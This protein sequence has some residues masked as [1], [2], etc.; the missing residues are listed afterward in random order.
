MK[1]FISLILACIMLLPLFGC[2]GNQGGT[3]STDGSAAGTEQSAAT[4]GTDGSQSETVPGETVS[5]DTLHAHTYTQTV[6]APTCTDDGYTTYTCACGETYV[7]DKVAAAG[8]SFGQWETTVEPT[9]TSTGTSERKCAVC[10]EKETR[11]LGKKLANHTHSYVTEVLDVATCT[12]EGVKR[13]TCT[14]GESYTE[15]TAKA[16]HSYKNT[17]VK[18]DCVNGGYTTHKCSV[19]DDAYVDAQTNALGHDYKDTVVASTCVSYGH[20]KYSCSRCGSY[21]TQKLPLAEHAYQDATCTTAK[22]CKVCGKTSGSALGHSYNA[23]G[24]CSRCGVKNPQAETGPVTFSATIKSDKNEKIAGITVTVYVDS[25]AQPAGSAVTGSNGVA[26][27]S[28]NRGG[29]YKVV[30]S[31]IPAGYS[32]KESYTFSSH[33]VN[34]NLACVPV[35]DPLDHSRAMY[36]VGSTMADFTLTDTDGNTYKLSQLMQQKKLIILDFWYVTCAPCKAEFPYF[37][38]ALEQYGD[39]ITLLALNPLDGESA[40][41]ELR[42][43]MEVT[44]PMV[45]ESI[46]LAKG[47]DVTAYPTTVFIDSN[48]KVVFI[49]EG[50]FSS[51]QAFLDKIKSYL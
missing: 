28:I 12:K 40:I 14:C 27:M 10:G 41:K 2:G 26:T 5:S 22:T 4:E 42:E 49:E 43:Q 18:P 33:Q 31:N 32:G 21:Y 35:L 24:N 25:A 13:L 30:L 29:S 46:G 1:K 7:S 23:D 9:E 47:F 11:T 8:H 50:Q 6:T 16:S 39:D 38:K 36:E 17:V 37:E 3:E 34:I 20:T 51:E 48:G 45:K 15:T 44:F 19:C